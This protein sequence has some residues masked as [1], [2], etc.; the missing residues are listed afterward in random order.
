MDEQVATETT[1]LRQGAELQGDLL[2]RQSDMEKL[3]KKVKAMAAKDEERINDASTFVNELKNSNTCMRGKL[4]AFQNQRHEHTKALLYDVS[5]MV[6]KGQETCTSL[7]DSIT[8]ELNTLQSNTQN[9]IAS[10]S[11]SCNVLKNALGT[12]N[13]TAESTLRSLQEHVTD[14]MGDVDLN[15]KNAQ[16]CLS[17]QNTQALTLVETINIHTVDQLKVSNSL[18]E[19]HMDHKDDVTVHAQQLRSMLKG[20]MEDCNRIATEYAAQTNA[21]LKSSADEVEQMLSSMLDNTVQGMCER[22][23]ATVSDTEAMKGDAMRMAD[24]AIG[25]IEGL[26]FAASEA[27]KEQTK[28]LTAMV[29][30]AQK[31]QCSSIQTL[32]DN[33]SVLHTTIGSISTGTKGQYDRTTAVLRRAFV[34]MDSKICD[35]ES[36]LQ[37]VTG[38]LVTIN[39]AYKHASSCA[40]QEANES[41]GS[42]SDYL[43]REM[44]IIS[45][46]VSQHFDATA[47][48]AQQQRESLESCMQATEA[49]KQSVASNCLESKGDTPTKLYKSESLAL[50]PT[51]DHTSIIREVLMQNGQDVDT[52]TLHTTSPS[53]ASAILR[54]QG[55]NGA[56][57]SNS[58]REISFEHE[59]W[60]KTSRDIYD[61]TIVNDVNDENELK[62]PNPIK[63]PTTPCMPTDEV[64][65]PLRGLSNNSRST[66]IQE[67]I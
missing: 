51:R 37:S 49:Y 2:A 28:E 30:Q 18:R 35:G 63:S 13:T 48:H 7:S 16:D 24:E 60:R 8:T 12:T 57:E 59:K 4:E 45:K 1:L 19:M 38:S 29:N 55:R 58:I 66:V 26:A 34:D 31:L 33:V 39:E 32:Q 20:N 9:K 56:I 17:V 53:S 14:W 62:A 15:M 52:N 54:E 65:E 50:R 27:Q 3:L 41:I 64:Y 61:V 36:T 40:R 11:E 46:E 10:V 21:L 44:D 6:S 23:D 67:F 43:S 22:H 47:D 42:F 5:G 25:T